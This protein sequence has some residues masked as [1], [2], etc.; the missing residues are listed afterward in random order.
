MKLLFLRGQ[1]PGD[2][3]KDQI[4]FDSLHENDDVWTH[5]AYELCKDGYGE[6][7]Y[8]K[9][10]RVT[11]YAP[12]FVERYVSRYREA[13]V[14]FDPDVVFARGGFGFMCEEAFRHRKAF[15]IHYGAGRRV[16]PKPGQPWDLVLVDDRTQLLKTRRLGYRAELFI[17]P[18]ADHIFR[19]VTGEKRYDVIHVANF[20]PNANKGHRFLLKRLQ[21]YKVLQVGIARPGWAK[22]WP[23]VT[24][25][26]WVP[27]KLLPGMYAQAKIGVVVTQGKDSCPRVIPEALACGCPLLVHSSTKLWW[28]KYVTSETGMSCSKATFHDQFPKMLDAWE[29]FDPR[30]YYE[31]HLS[32]KVAAE[33]IRRLIGDVLS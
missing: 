30:G 27:R 28:E 11:R 18:A 12:N 6:V 19:P 8:E 4:A 7:W 17:K 29:S 3:P 1:V 14:S 24:F 5:L 22:K 25:K 21:P 20:N 23:N 2:R 26:G 33:H 9:G 10:S 13:E 15:K 31:R 16:I 32:L